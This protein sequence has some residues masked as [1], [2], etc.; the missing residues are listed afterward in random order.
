MSDILDDMTIRNLKRAE[1]EYTRREKG[2]FG[3]R[4]LPTGRKVFFYLYRVDGVR[5]FL[6][7]GQYKDKQHPNGITLEE[8]RRAFT[9]EQ[10]KVTALKAGRSEGVDPAKAKQE[11]AERRIAAEEER[12]K[13]STVEELVKEYIEKHAMKFMRSCEEDVRIL[14]K[15]VI[16]SW[17]KRKATDVTKRDVVLLL[18]G[19]VERGAPGMSN[20]TFRVIR[21]MFNFAVER[22]ILPHSP[23]IGVKELAPKVA[24]ERAL[25]ADEIKTLWGNLDKAAISDEIRGALKLMLLTAQRPGEVIGLHTGEIDGDWWT[26]PSERAKNGKAHRVFLSH[27]A[28]GIIAQS[29]ERVKDIREI[30]LEKTY[31]GHIFPCPHRDKVQSIDAHALSMVIRRNFAWPLLDKKGKP[32]YGKDGKP[33][34]ENRLGVDYFTPHDLR[35]TAATF[36]AQMGFMDEV[37]DAVLNHAKQGVIKVYNLYRYDKE[38]QQALETWERKL[39][40]IVEGKESRVLPMRTRRKAA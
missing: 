13:S 3:I 18:E 38:K 24:R 34:T 20:N 16:P 22:G 8:A 4:V 26:I 31:E 10:G 11:A 23:A 17:G 12:R 14:K 2:G 37:I 27:S 6:N 39:L 25:S 36:M 7:L 28:K 35:R 15:D 21:K 40:G 29:I 30:P 1:K 32:L 9:I 19:I 33:A 5:R